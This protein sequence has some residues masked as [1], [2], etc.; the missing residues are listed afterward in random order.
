MNPLLSGP[1]QMQHMGMNSFLGNSPIG[2]IMKFMNEYKRLKSN[3]SELGDFLYKQGK[4]NK[5]QLDEIQ[6]FN[7]DPSKIGEY[8]INSGSIPQS[9]LNSL[10]NST[11]QVQQY[12]NSQ[13]TPN[14]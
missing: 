13:N 1:N 10:Q 14:N 3:P 7:G 6:K 12:M 11:A 9:Q 2:N 5:S 8:L 4:I